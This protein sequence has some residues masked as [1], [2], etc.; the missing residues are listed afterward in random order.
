MCHLCDV[1]SFWFRI[2]RYVSYIRLSDFFLSHDDS[3]KCTTDAVHVTKSM[4]TERISM[5]TGFL[6]RAEGPLLRITEHLSHLKAPVVL[7]ETGLERR[8]TPKART[9][10]SIPDS[11]S[12]LIL[13]WY[14]VCHR[15]KMRCGGYS[16]ESLRN[17]SFVNAAGQVQCHSK[18]FTDSW[19]GTSLLNW[20]LKCSL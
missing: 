7:R 13:I 3:H 20:K 14:V 9:F 16:F 2:F 15:F 4:L 17:S 8:V 18:T 11:P 10:P 19:G 1:S 5:W 12:A 6:T